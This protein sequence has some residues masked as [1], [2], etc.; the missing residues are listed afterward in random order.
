MIIMYEEY[1]ELRRTDVFPQSLSLILWL[2]I[3]RHFDDRLG[4]ALKELLF[5]LIYFFCRIVFVI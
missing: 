5:S 1:N 3:V 2:L 4:E